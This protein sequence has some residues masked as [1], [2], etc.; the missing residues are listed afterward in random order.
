MIAIPSF[1]KSRFCMLNFACLFNI[2][3]TLFKWFNYY[4]KF[5]C[6]LYFYSFMELVHQG[7]FLVY[8]VWQFVIKPFRISIS[9]SH[10]QSFLSCRLLIF[11]LACHSM[12]KSSVFCF[13]SRFLF[14]FSLH[15]LFTYLLIYITSRTFA[16]K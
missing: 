8:N 1:T 6:P 12:F 11:P 9:V 10:V 3:S 16:L 5:L 4:Q 7:I 15:V 14:I 2:F 13:C